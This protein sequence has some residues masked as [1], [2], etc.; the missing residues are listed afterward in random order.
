MQ[1]PALFLSHG[2]PM[3]A[4]EDEPTTRFLRDLPKLLPKPAAIVVASAHWETDIPLVSGS[5]HPD[6]IHDF[7][8]FPRELYTL[9]YRAPG[10]PDLAA[11]IKGLLGEADIEAAIDGKRGLDHGAWDPLIV[12]YPGADIPVLEISVQPARD[13]AWHYRVGEALAPLKDDNVLIVG[14]GNLTHNL[15]EAFRGHHPQTPEWVEAFAEWVAAK[16]EDDDIQSLLNWQ[17]AAP[18]ANRNHPT[19]EHFLPFFVALGAARNS[20]PRRLNKQLA[21]GVLA[22]DAYVWGGGSG[23]SR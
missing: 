19:P 21:L 5:P 20:P 2:S 4:L 16:V 10:A 12:M 17:R 22:M 15:N 8:G 13:A 9:R 23:G 1:M 14:S 3:L 18:H 7:Y 11:K 6:T